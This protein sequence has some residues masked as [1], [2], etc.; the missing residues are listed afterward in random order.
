LRQQLKTI[1]NL[2][3]KLNTNSILKLL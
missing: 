1:M 3:L 2:F